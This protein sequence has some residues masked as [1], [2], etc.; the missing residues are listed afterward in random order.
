MIREANRRSEPPSPPEA[1]S[2]IYRSSDCI[3][4]SW[5]I[6]NDNGEKIIGYRV[7]IEDSQGYKIIH[8]TDQLEFSAKNLEKGK[9]FSFRVAAVNLIGESAFGAASHFE[10]LLSISEKFLNTNSMKF[11][12]IF[13]F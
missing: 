13:I 12:E 1:P 5:K 7:E 3:V 6:P 4:I 10:T 8:S 11:Q 9:K 2:L